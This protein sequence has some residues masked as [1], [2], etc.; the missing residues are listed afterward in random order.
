MHSWGDENVDWDGLNKA[1]EFIGRNLRRWGRVNVFQYK[2]KWGTVRVYCSFG[3]SQLFT[4]TH[5]G[6]AYSRYPDWLW[7]LD[8]KYISKLMGPLNRI[9]VPYQIWLYK[10]LYGRALKKWPHLRLEILS[11]ADYHQLLAKFG[12]HY[13]RK[14]EYQYEA[15]IDWHKDNFVYPQETE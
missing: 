7:Q 8:C 4:I 9:V 14:S 5:P 3:W 13:V 12:V 15:Y 6:Y 11:G 1:A 10:F 2:E